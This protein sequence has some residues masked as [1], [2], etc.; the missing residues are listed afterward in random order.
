[1]TTTQSRPLELDFAVDGMTCA[2]CVRRVEQA[3]VKVDGVHDVSVNLATERAHVSID[4]GIVT[5]EQLTETVSKAGYTPGT[6]ALPGASLDLAL[7]AEPAGEV[8]FDIEGMT[9]ASCVRRVEVALDKLEGVRS[10][11]VNLATERATVTF[12]PAKVQ[13]VT[14]AKAVEAAGYGVA[15]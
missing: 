10:S 2:S 15:A 8:T 14:L 13:V 7:A 3:L 11:S 4:P 1:M 5:A 12:D 9:C 6:I